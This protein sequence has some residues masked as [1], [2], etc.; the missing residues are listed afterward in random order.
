MNVLR[1]INEPT[2]AIAYGLD[3]K[4]TGERNVL[5]FDL[6]LLT[7]EERIL[8]VKATTSDTHL[9]GEYFDNRLVNHFAQDFK[10]RNK[11]DLSST[12]R[13]PACLRSLHRSRA[14]HQLLPLLTRARFEELC[15]DL[16]QSSLEAASTSSPQS[17]RRSSRPT[18]CAHQAHSR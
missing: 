2:A 11:T 6:S 3:K 10:R 13:A 12:F 15:Q 16:S 1:I 4:V 18:I 5:T 14:W 8:K 17:A 9:G 7:I